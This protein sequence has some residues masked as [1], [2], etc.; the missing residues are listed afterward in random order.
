MNINVRSLKIPG[1]ACVPVCSAGQAIK[2][3]LK[4]SETLEENSTPVTCS[5]MLTLD[6]ILFW[7]VYLSVGANWEE[8]KSF[9]LY[10]ESI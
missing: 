10:G 7:G 1:F 2:R 8:I 3:Y 6:N 4:V 5:S 9:D